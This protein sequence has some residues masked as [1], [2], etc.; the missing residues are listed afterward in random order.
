MSRFQALELEPC[1]KVLER[2][3]ERKELAIAIL[4]N[5]IKLSRLPFEDEGWDAV[6]S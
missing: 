6:I 4:A 3:V 5:M 2:K 1:V